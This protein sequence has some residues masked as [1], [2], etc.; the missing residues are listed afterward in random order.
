MK[1]MIF[2][3]VLSAFIGVHPR[4]NCPFSTLLFFRCPA[5][6]G[7]FPL[8]VGELSDIGSIR[9]HGEDLA[10]RLRRSVVKCH[11]ILKTLASAAEDDPIAFVGPDGMGVAAGNVGQAAEVRAVG[12]ERVELEASV[13]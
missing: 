1:T 10:V 7:V 3:S 5:R 13:A 9:A 2:E 4:L 12:P 8:V 6:A 11:L